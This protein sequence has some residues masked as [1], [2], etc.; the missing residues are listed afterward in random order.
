MWQDKALQWLPVAEGT[1][2][3]VLGGQSCSTGAAL[4]KAHP[5]VLAASA[6][7]AF[8]R[9]CTEGLV[10]AWSP[11]SNRAEWHCMSLDTVSIS[12]W[13][14]AREMESV[15]CGGTWQ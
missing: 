3:D 9:E 12:V 4:G 5:W 2:E 8:V 13:W 6:D 15:L 1:E 14:I 11:P 7:G 10:S